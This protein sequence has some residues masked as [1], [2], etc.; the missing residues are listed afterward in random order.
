MNKVEAMDDRIIVKDKRSDEPFP[1]VLVITGPTATG[2]TAL[3]IKIAKQI[4]G[5]IVSADSMQIYKYM[6][7]GTAKPSIE[8]MDGVRHHMIDIVP[9]WEDYSIA[10]YV[11]DASRCIDDIAKR[12]KKPILAGGTG[13]YIDSLLKGRTF[14]A[15]GDN[16]LRMQYEAAY[17]NI[18]GEA[19]LDILRGFDAESAARLHCNDKKRIVRALETYETTGKPISRHDAE[20]NAL[21]LR[22]ESIKFA[23]MF[24]DRAALYKRINKRVDEMIS[25][26]L[27]GE[28]QA[29]QKMGV[30]RSNTSMQAIGYKEIYDA[31][32]N[33]SSLD[34]VADLIKMESR[35]Y[36]KRQLSWLRR[37]P[38]I[39]W[40]KWENSPAL[41]N[42]ADKILGELKI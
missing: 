1:R 2:K 18:G 30:T 15:R 17:D 27:E 23:L 40:I 5:E 13:L 6:D 26:G 36:A 19:M 4:G 31:I 10:R 41:D 24:S 39:N 25:T 32:N 8:E 34:Q 28:V 42:A 38:D 3:S 20:T 12:G 7:I 9:P 29:L 16:E 11:E 33:N 21:P 35:R 14:L 22:Y 37:D